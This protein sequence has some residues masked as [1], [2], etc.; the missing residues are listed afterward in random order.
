MDD[1]LEHDPDWLRAKM[2]AE[3]KDPN[4]WLR[5]TIEEIE[6]HLRYGLPNL[7][8]IGWVIVVLLSLIL[9][10]VWSLGT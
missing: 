5:R 9:W 3:Q 1:D 6:V 2:E 7:K 8:V 4:Y 10:R